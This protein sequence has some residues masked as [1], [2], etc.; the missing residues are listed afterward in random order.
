MQPSCSE[1]KCLAATFHKGVDQGA[2]ETLPDVLAALP[3]DTQSASSAGI[4]A[5]LMNTTP[6][7]PRQNDIPQPC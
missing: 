4:R 5:T 3:E 2:T 1:A 6:K 7:Q